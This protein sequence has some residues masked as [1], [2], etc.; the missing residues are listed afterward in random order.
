MRISVVRGGGLLGMA[1]ETTLDSAHLDES[2][3]QTLQATVDSAQPFAQPAAAAVTAKGADMFSY[4]L[5]VQDGERSQ[6]LRRTDADLTPELR[7]L[8]GLVLSA[9]E[10][11]RRVLRPGQEA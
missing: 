9:P 2:A 6:T 11:E 5:R 8:V 4:E 10:R 1:T 7:E 3:R